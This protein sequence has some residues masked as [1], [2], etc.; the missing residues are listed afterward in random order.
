MAA[1][2]WRL[3]WLM[4]LSHLH[5]F[6]CCCCLCCCCV[7]WSA[8][9]N[10][11]WQS[12]RVTWCICRSTDIQEDFICGFRWRSIDIGPVE[13]KFTSKLSIYQ[14]EMI[15]T[16]WLL[17]TRTSYLLVIKQLM[18][19]PGKCFRNCRKESRRRL[20]IIV[21]AISVCWIFP[22]ITAYLGASHSYIFC[23]LV[24][25]YPNKLLSRW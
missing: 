3:L 8:G 18:N 6:C 22:S 14:R 16:Q 11:K 25:Y 21:N 19:W 4:S 23:S 1:R 17:T 15:S 7:E 13:Y 10:F 5:M 12:R 9:Y 2:W 24:Q 20:K